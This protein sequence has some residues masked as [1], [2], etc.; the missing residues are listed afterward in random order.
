MGSLSSLDTSLI[1]LY[2]VELEKTLEGFVIY[3]EIS[4]ISHS[5]FALKTCIFLPT[6]TVSCYCRIVYFSYITVLS[7]IL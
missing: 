5:S 3:L 4:D 1:L 7:L 2:A 6:L